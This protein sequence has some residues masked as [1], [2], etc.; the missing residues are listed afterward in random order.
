MSDFDKV[1]NV[2]KGI[3]ALKN[4]DPK[5]N[6]NV[7]SILQ[8]VD[9]RWGTNYG[10]FISAVSG[11]A[12]NH[13]FSKAVPTDVLRKAVE[14]YPQLKKADGISEKLPA[15]QAEM[16]GGAPPAAGAGTATTTANTAPYAVPLGSVAPGAKKKKKHHEEIIDWSSQFARTADSFKE[17]K[18]GSGYDLG[19]IYKGLKVSQ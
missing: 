2:I 17:F 19:A 14:N 8:Q 10:A 1:V 16:G 15:V 7:V 4:N 3:A 6:T 13:N 18:V 9:K 12:E 11:A 5:L